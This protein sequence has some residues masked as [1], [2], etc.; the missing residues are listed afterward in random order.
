M[1]S[2]LPYFAPLPPGGWCCQRKKMECGC[3]VRFSKPLP[4]LWKNLRYLLSYLWPNQ[5]F[6][7]LFTDQ[8]PVSREPRK[9][10]DREVYT[11]ENSCMNRT[12][13]RIK[14]MWTKQR[15]LLSLGL[16]FC[17]GFPGPSR[18]GSLNLTSNSVSTCVTIGSRLQWIKSSADNFDNI[19]SNI[20][21][22]ITYV[23]RF[24]SKQ[25]SN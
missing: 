11:P 6:W 4:Y 25:N 15:R 10:L 12:S 20:F 19:I 18:N 17:Y 21:S 2:F 3:V 24:L 9:L 23:A 7:N 13:V 16:R 5:K 14:N 22:K 8:G 1:K